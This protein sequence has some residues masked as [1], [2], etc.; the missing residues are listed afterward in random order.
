MISITKKIEK[1]YPNEN[2][3]EHDKGRVMENPPIFGDYCLN[4]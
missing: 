1:G 4:I 2:Y 3:Q